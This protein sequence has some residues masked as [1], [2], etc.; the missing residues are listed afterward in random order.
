MINLIFSVY[1]TKA[2]A[3]GA[4]FTKVTKG[5]ALR[6]FATAANDAETLVGRFPTDFVLYEL[7]EIDLSSGKL[8]SHVQPVSLGFALEHVKEQLPLWPKEETDSKRT[9][10][11]Q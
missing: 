4:P 11:S 2:E 1:D 5:A 7:G 9:T 10:V 6:D 3:Y 8:K